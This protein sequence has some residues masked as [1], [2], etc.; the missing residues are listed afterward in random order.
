MKT[1]R[2][3]AS[4][5][6]LLLTACDAPRDAVETTVQATRLD[7]PS[8]KTKEVKAP[9]A[10]G[11]AFKMANDTATGPIGAPPSTPPMSEQ[12]A[13][14]I[15]PP[16]DPKTMAGAGLP[17]VVEPAIYV[18]GLSQGA[19]PSAAVIGWTKPFVNVGDRLGKARIV[20]IDMNGVLLDD[21]TRIVV[22]SSANA[23]AVA[24]ITYPA[25]EMQMVP[26]IA[27]AQRIL[28][29]TG[30]VST[31]PPNATGPALPLKS[32]SMNNLSTPTPTEAKGMQPVLRSMQ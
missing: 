9:H 30:T 15:V 17:L 26:N 10:H 13:P 28:A 32:E 27:P 24:A 4:S 2:I 8:M 16:I 1:L 6:V 5:V 14:N 20:K 19:R 11:V 22:T 21:G 25:T 31:P 7:I 23:A 29:P 12:P 3:A 18:V